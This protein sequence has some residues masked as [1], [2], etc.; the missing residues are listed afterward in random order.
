MSELPQGRFTGQNSSVVDTNAEKH[1]RKEK[2]DSI[3][4]FLQ[5]TSDSEYTCL[6]FILNVSGLVVVDGY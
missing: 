5:W 3:T 2:L 6:L 1:E 4:E